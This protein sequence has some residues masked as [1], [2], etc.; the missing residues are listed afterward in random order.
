[1]TRNDLKSMSTG[2]LWALHEKIAAALTAKLIAE[3]SNLEERLKQL[4]RGTEFRR[5]KPSTG[6]LA[7]SACRSEVPESR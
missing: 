7:I 5:N 4:K 6:R 3:T 1:M 2:E